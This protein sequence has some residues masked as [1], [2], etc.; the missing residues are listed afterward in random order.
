[1][2]RRPGERARH[3][4]RAL[5]FRAKQGE[6]EKQG[7]RSAGA[8]A[9]K[10]PFADLA[11]ERR[12][13]SHHHLAPY[14]AFSMYSSRALRMAAPLEDTRTRLFIQSSVQHHIRQ[15]RDGGGLDA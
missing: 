6:P 15:Q 8:G 10:V 13:K 9:K 1:V 11:M 5:G 7:Q 4:R 2:N 12:K 14:P 3:G